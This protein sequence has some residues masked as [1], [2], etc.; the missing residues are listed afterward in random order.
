MQHVLAR[1][2]EEREAKRKHNKPAD[3]KTTE[4]LVAEGLALGDG[5]ETT[6]VDLLGVELNGALGE[7]ETLLDD[8]G[9]LA[10]A[11]APLTE[12]TLGLGGPD[13]N[14]LA[15]GGDT[16]LN[17]SVSL[18]G[19]LAHEELVQLSVENSIGNELNEKSKYISI[20]NFHSLIH[21]LRAMFFSLL[22]F[23]FLL[24]CFRAILVFGVVREWRRKGE[25]RE[26]GKLFSF[27]LFYC[28]RKKGTK[29]S[30]SDIRKKP[31]IRKY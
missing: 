12:N 4:E 2:L 16:D 21:K 9:E 24:N 22:T 5:G 20:S 19:E 31:E 15:G 18:L 1:G 29:I 10:N 7:V 26:K 3:S 27:F 25:K 28:L 17:S 14:L 6:G 13:D 23:L 8:G 30:G 11:A